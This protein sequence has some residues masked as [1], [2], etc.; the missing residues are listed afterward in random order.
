MSVELGAD[1]ADGGYANAQLTHG[2]SGSE[3]GLI[4]I[5]PTRDMTGLAAIG[6]GTAN[7]LHSANTTSSVLYKVRFKT[8]QTGTSSRFNYPSG[9]GS[10]SS[11]VL[12]EI[13]A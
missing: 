3:T 8:N 4:T 6:M 5:L 9:T 7:Y 13:G 10:T 12:M 2:A 11:I 1:G